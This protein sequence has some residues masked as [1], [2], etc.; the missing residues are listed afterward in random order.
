MCHD[1]LGGQFAVDG[2]Q[3]EMAGWGQGLLW[4]LWV[5]AVLVDEISA[6]QKSMGTHSEDIVIRVHNSFAMNILNHC[7]IQNYP[8]TL[9][10]QQIVQSF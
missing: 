3:M 10:E 9:E 5:P 7:K 1:V 4:Y 8:D 2:E 6:G